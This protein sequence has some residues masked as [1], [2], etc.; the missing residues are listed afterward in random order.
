MRECPRC[1]RCYDDEVLVCPEEGTNTKVTLPGA[2]LMA[3]RYL[4]EKRLGR[5]A[6]GQVYLARDQNLIT[7]RVAVKTV[8]PDILSDEDMQEG[9]AIAR[10]E[11]EA[12][13]AASIR[14]PNV[15]DVTDFGKSPEG[16]FYLVMEYVQGETLHHL[17]R[18]EGTLSVHRTLILMR[19][20][21]GGVEAAHDEGILHRDLKP[22]NIFIMQQKKKSGTASG[23]GIVKVGDFGLAK[24]VNQ[25]IADTSG[26]SGAGPA[27]RGII[28]TPEYMAPEQMQMETQLDARADVYALGVIAY[29]MLG[30]RPP[31]SGDLTQLVMQKIMN[32]PPPLSGLRSDIP[33]DVERAV[34]HAL[35]KDPAKRPATVGE[36]LEEFEKAADSEED[37]D[38]KAGDSRVVVMAPVGAEV[39][40]DDERH[41]SVGRSGRVILKSIAPGRHVLRV[42]RAG[43]T[44]DERVIEIR[45]DSSEQIIQAVLR[46]HASGGQLTPSRGGSIGGSMSGPNSSLPGVVM[47]AQ[48][49]SRFA[50]G[51]KFCGRCGGRIFLPVNE[52]QGS[53]SGQNAGAPGSINAGPSV[54]GYGT[55]GVRCTGC[56]TLYAAGTKFCGRCGISIGQSAQPVHVAPRPGQ[57]TCQT[58]RTPYSAGTKFCGRCGTILRT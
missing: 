32:D 3:G 49:S 33:K 44:D 50:A 15:V 12:R 17:L 4:L 57:V 6:M 34:M 28:G 11:R 48:C 36:W 8:R 42:S 51:V 52:A 16:V 14:H 23:D 41:G 2:P 29:H 1:E 30:G 40:V 35:E 43:D 20:V 18:R 10:F 13:T 54:V 53:Q 7:R 46:P 58:C 9:E 37:E 56:G 31:F 55:S 25:A 5:G 45:P 24:I 39:Y 21:A 26:V 38:E 27:S 22:A 47:C 19:Q